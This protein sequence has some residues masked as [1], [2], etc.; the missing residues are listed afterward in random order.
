MS[1]H[2]PAR[3]VRVL[4]VASFSILALA[5]SGAGERAVASP[6]PPPVSAVPD[7]WTS[8]D[9]NCG[10]SG[11]TTAVGADGFDIEGGGAD[12]WDTSDGFRFVYQSYSGNFD[13]KA[14]VAS[15]ENTNSWAKALSTTDPVMVGLC[16][17]AH[18]NGTLCTAEFR[19]VSLSAYSTP[20]TSLDINAG[21]AGTTLP[22]GTDGYNIEGGGAD[23][24]GTSDGFRFVYQSYSGN[25]DLR[26][27]VASVENTDSWAKAGVM[28]RQST[29]ADSIH[30][31]MVATPGNGFSFQ[32]R[33]TTGGESSFTSGGSTSYPN[34]WVRLL[35]VG[36]VVTGCVA[37][38]AAGTEWEAVDSLTLST[39]DP[40]LVGMCVTAHNN[41]TLATAEFRGV[42]LATYS[43]PTPGTGTGLT[44]VYYDNP[45]LTNKKLSRTDSQVNFT[46]GTGSPDASVGA[47]TFSVI[48]TGQVEA[49]YTET[50]T[51]FVKTDDGVRLWVNDQL[52]VDNWVNQGA[53][54]KSGTIALAAGQKYDLTLEYYE[55]SG[56][57]MA[58]LRWRSPMTLKALIPQSQ[59]Y[60]TA[61]KLVGTGTGLAA[62]YYDNMDWTGSFVQRT[63]STVNFDWGSG[64][65]DPAIGPDTFSA[66]WTGQIEVQ[67]TGTYTFTILTDDGIRLWVD[68]NLVVDFPVDQSPTE[69]SGS[70]RLVKGQKANLRMEYWEN[71]GGAVAKLSWSSGT[72]D[73][74]IVPQTQLYPVDTISPQLLHATTQSSD[75]TKVYLRFS[76]AMDQATAQTTTN[77]T[78]TGSLTVNS[79]VLSADKKVVT[80][81]ASGNVTIGT[82]EVTA[83]AAIKN[84]AQEAI[85]QTTKTI[86]AGNDQGIPDT[87]AITM[88]LTTDGNHSAIMSGEPSSYGVPEGIGETLKVL[89]PGTDATVVTFTQ[90]KKIGG[91]GAVY[92]G[93]SG[94]AMSGSV[95][96]TGGTPNK[97][98]IVVRHSATSAFEGDLLIEAKVNRELRAAKS[99]TPMDVTFSTK[100]AYLSDQTPLTVTAQTSPVIEGLKFVNTTYL[101]DFGKTDQVKETTLLKMPA[102]S[103]TDASGTAR[104]MDESPGVHCFLYDT[105]SLE[106]TSVAQFNAPPV[107]GSKKCRKKKPVPCGETSYN[108]QD[109]TVNGSIRLNDG[110]KKL[111][112]QDLII[113]GRGFDYAFRRH[114]GSNDYYQVLVSAGATV[115]RD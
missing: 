93:E 60:P 97:G 28:V 1:A 76:E 96:T 34:S 47:D 83:S 109:G 6:L 66:V 90:S 11:T 35:R 27:R 52:L 70:I 46:W 41:G 45:D 18:D 103:L 48:W 3:F 30:A 113:Q 42:S 12:I 102:F 99:V 79:A 31:I 5:L 40:V 77:Y 114:Y 7:T 104:S 32:R 62:V 87:L 10:V 17:T 92:F 21:V 91:K 36:Q 81:T 100:Y 63:D 43:A 84:L 108:P 67:F 55:N 15:V 82:T 68:G 95:M 61:T 19:S 50:Y 57:A 49:Q 89:V 20:W 44:G 39:T 29:D 2:C 23:I 64:S 115:V 54:E 59:L 65:P 53:T 8:E 69:R 105:I 107:A 73:Q 24:W 80:L 98:Y 22:V 58:E 71:G 26:A 33:T 86:V 9:I 56:D 38:D 88:I 94:T 111:D 37:R 112:Y 101:M 85:A 16:V 51:F 13:I 78:L 75:L 106:Q 4:A 74:E 25:F 14:R 110:E 72:T